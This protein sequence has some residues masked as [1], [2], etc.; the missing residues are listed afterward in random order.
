MAIFK[1]KEYLVHNV[2][3]HT[4]KLLRALLAKYFLQ[5][6]LRMVIKKA[7][8]LGKLIISLDIYQPFNNNYTIN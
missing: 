1:S 2:V 5:F 8:F 6:S 4:R 3:I 7:H